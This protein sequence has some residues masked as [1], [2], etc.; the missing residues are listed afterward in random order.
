MGAFHYGMKVR[1]AA[2]ALIYRK[3]LRLSK[4]A[5]GETAS[6]KI[7]NLLS[8]DVSRFDLVSVFIHHMWQAPIVTLCVLYFMW[9]EAGYAGV[10]GI[11][12]VFI[13]VPLQGYTGKLSAVYRKAT[14]LK[15]DERVRLM[16]EILSGIQVIKMYAWEK[17]FAKLIRFARKA[18]LDIIIKSSYVRGLYMTFNLFTTRMALFGTLVTLVLMDRPVTAST[19]FVITSLLASVAQTMSQ[20]FVRGISEI[21]ELFVAVRRLESIMIS[22]EYSA[23]ALTNG[24]ASLRGNVT[25]KYALSMRDLVVKWNAHSNEY[26]LESINLNVKTRELLGVIGPVGSGK[27]SFLQTILGEL[28]VVSGKINV[29]GSLSYA[30]QEAWVFAA[31]VRQNILFGS[32][33]DKKRYNNVVKA[34][35]LEK[36]F[37]Q[38]S[39]GDLTI[40]GDR[41]ASLSGGQKARINLARAI[42]READIYLLDDPLS[43]VDTHVSK[44]LYDL[45]INGYLQNK[46]RILVTH[47]VHHLKDADNI[48][49]LTNGKIDNQGS[50][51]ELSESDNIYAQLLTAEP[52]PVELERPKVTEKEVAKRDRKM[53]LKSVRSVASMM[54]ETSLPEA[55][56]PEGGDSES[57]DEEDKRE[58]R[59]KD[60]QEE[61][62][63]GKVQGSLLFHYLFASGKWMFASCVMLFFLLAQGAAMGVDYFVSYWVKIEEVK[64][65]GLNDTDPA[66]DSWQPYYWEADLWLEIYGALIASVFIIALLRS[67]SFYKLAMT[68]SQKL[69]DVM[70][71]NVINARMRFFDTNPSGRILNRFSKDIGSIDELLPKAILDAG[72]MILMTAGSIVLVAVVNPMFLI[73]VGIVAL[74]ST[75]LRHVFLKTSKNIKRLEGVMRSPVFSHLNATLQGLTTIRAFNAENILRYEFDKH[76]DCHTSAWF[77]YIAA[78]SAFGLYM[79]MLCFVFITAVTFSFLTFGK[80]AGLSGGE[81]GLAIT[82]STALTGLFQWGLRQ[83]AEVSNQLMSVERVLEYKVLPKEK[84]PAKPLTPPKSWPETGEIVFADMGLRYYENGKLVLKNMNLVIHPKEKVGIVGR[85]GAGKSSLITALF[86]L[87]NV[88]GSI[89]IDHLDTKELTLNTLRSKIS[90][91]PQDPVLFS[92]TLRYNLDPF[93]EYNDEVLYKAIEDVELKDPSNIIN[94]L[95]NRVMDRGSNYS[96]GQRQLICLAR[97]IIRNN[98]ILMLDE[99]TANVDPQTDALIQKTIRKKFADCTVLT[100]A[101]RLNTIMDS[102]KVLVMDGGTMVEFEHPHTLLQ[103]PNGVFSGMVNE[104][105]RNLATQL[106]KVAQ[107]SYARRH[108]SLPE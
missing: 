82:Q 101:H 27:S 43:A 54:S 5:L 41:G 26:A 93:E 20:M 16:D 76:Q 6:G 15:T 75:V 78:S 18:E 25:E 102:D 28:D 17:P 42:Y 105:G 57:E 65:A 10:V 91:I 97:A 37:E 14:A 99:A 68:S 67:M 108:H 104:T 69:H 62:S 19:V 60:L 66:V 7:V 64:A 51:K 4:T 11:T 32:E 3:S 98:K 34:C 90:I 92:G 83:A 48:I 58:I 30:S 31:T 53:S 36:D 45:C 9:L 1:A 84:E 74:F 94:R 56:L 72:Q 80:D 47:Q 39:N 79:D 23:L 33:F 40:V 46:T 77:M 21:A 100:V 55:F 35:A 106:K 44:H 49:I 52:E 85:T 81:V 70:F 86:R 59:F 50:F 38:F 73:V 22:E 96:V 87:A 88:E 24:T 95:E 61:S 8:N 103:N 89:R 12:C 13:V 29:N 107:D 63:K 2:C 71:D